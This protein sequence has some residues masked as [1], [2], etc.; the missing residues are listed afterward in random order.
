MILHQTQSFFATA[1]QTTSLSFTSEFLASPDCCP[2]FTMRFTV[3]LIA[4]VASGAVALPQGSDSW[5]NWQHTSA[6]A[7]AHP[8]ATDKPAAVAQDKGPD[9]KPVDNAKPSPEPK[10]SIIPTHVPEVKDA[11]ASPT[12][13]GQNAWEDW[14][15][16]TPASPPHPSVTT[17]SSNKESPVHQDQ[18]QWSNWQSS[19]SPAP[20]APAKDQPSPTPAAGKNPAPTGKQPSPSPD[21]PK[22]TAP[23]EHQPSS[24]AAPE[25]SPSNGDGKDTP[26]PAAT[27]A[28]QQGS[29]ST[30]WSRWVKARNNQQDPPR[31][32]NASPSP[33][34]PKQA[35]KASP[36]PQ[37]QESKP[38]PSPDSRFSGPA[39]EV[40]AN[41]GADP[42][43][44]CTWEFILTCSNQAVSAGSSCLA[45]LAEA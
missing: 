12:P 21:A 22:N 35:S 8:A 3:A 17:P 20:Q 34:Q 45:P 27:P 18:N 24:A 25:K 43:S 37:K 13:E 28:D 6:A 42:S 39:A 23:A 29:G 33:V 11:V 1:Y 7:I 4:L 31:Q 16:T 14:K 19:V 36:A 26:A 30:E 41:L 44:T 9:S 40:S 32:M 10:T 2:P 15:T 38:S 5:G